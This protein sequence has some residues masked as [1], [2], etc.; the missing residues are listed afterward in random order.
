MLRVAG[1]RCGSTYASNGWDGNRQAL[2]VFLGRL[3]LPAGSSMAFNLAQLAAL[4][5]DDPRSK[6]TETEPKTHPCVNRP[7]RWSI[8]HG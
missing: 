3:L 7:A 2:N 4:C 5:A 6:F 1:A 8:G